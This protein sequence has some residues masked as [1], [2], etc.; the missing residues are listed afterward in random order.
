MLVAHEVFIKQ[1]YVSLNVLR[2]RHLGAQAC[3]I[4]APNLSLPDAQLGSASLV[5]R[6]ILENKDREDYHARGLNSMTWSLHNLFITSGM[7]EGIKIV[8][9]CDAAGHSGHIF[10]QVI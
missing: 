6:Y 9:Q 10:R 8:Y 5:S 3:I 4:E 7:H 2:S 1:A